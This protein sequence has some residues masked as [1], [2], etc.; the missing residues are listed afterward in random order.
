MSSA[1]SVVDVEP[2]PGLSQAQLAEFVILKRCLVRLEEQWLNL[3]G[4]QD[5]R[6]VKFTGAFDQEFQTRINQTE[7]IG[8]MEAEAVEK[9]Y[10]AELARITREFEELQKNLFR[11][12]THGYYTSYQASMAHLKDLLG[13]DFDALQAAHEMEFPVIS[14]SKTDGRKVPVPEDPKIAFSPHETDR[15]IRK[16]KQDV[17][18]SM[19]QSDDEEAQLSD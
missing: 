3:H 8:R 19:V 7:I 17:Q 11:R 14:S 2:P 15:Q 12:I 18:A 4:S 1:M 9:Q 16:I 10:Q 13:P 5:P 6:Q